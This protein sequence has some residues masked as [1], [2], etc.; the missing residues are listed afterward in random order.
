MTWSK[1]RLKDGESLDLLIDE[2]GPNVLE[3]TFAFDKVLLELIRDYIEGDLII[4]KVFN[5]S[6][7]VIA[8]IPFIKDKKGRYWSIP[9]VS[10]G[11]F[12]CEG[13]IDEKVL[14]LFKDDK[15]FI[16]GTHPLIRSGSPVKVLTYIELEDSS[17][18]QLYSWK[19]KL[20]SQIK[21]S[22]KTGFHCKTGGSELVNIFYGLYAENMASLGS[23]VY[24]IDLFKKILS[25]YT[26]NSLVFVVYKESEIVATSIVLGYRG[27][28]E[29]LWA[30]SNKSYNRAGGNMFLYWKMIEW[31]IENGYKIFS[32]G[33]S[34]IDSSQYKFKQQW[35][36]KDK[37][38]YSTANWQLGKREKLKEIFK[39]LWRLMPTKISTLVGSKI[40]RGIY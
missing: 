14:N 2:I 3:A 4:Y 1:E 15:Y 29:V 18:K 17:E 19:S 21:K 32:F 40:T 6:K 39:V 36:S 20:R 5:G 26:K 10:T 8:I 25:G 24:S 31:S 22:V 27:Y 38:I 12:L 23:P 7:R 9:F 13:G 34:T 35:N 30:A 28:A 11:G 16:R 33:R 37:Y